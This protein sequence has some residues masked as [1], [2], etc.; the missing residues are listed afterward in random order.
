MTS[1]R[2][3]VSAVSRRTSRN[4]SAA[5]AKAAIQAYLASDGNYRRR[6]RPR[7][8]RRMMDFIVGGEVPERY[9]G[10]MMEE[11]AVDGVDPG[12]GRIGKARP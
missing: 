8:V 3:A 9:M 12:S 7:P 1:L 10:M 2:T 11:L 6:P 4:A 5:L